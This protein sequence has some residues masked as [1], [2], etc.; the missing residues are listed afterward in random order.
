V[1]S[2]P[3]LPHVRWQHASVNTASVKQRTNM[4]TADSERPNLV[5]LQSD[6]INHFKVKELNFFVG[7]YIIQQSY[8][9][10]DIHKQQLLIT[11]AL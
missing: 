11:F 5:Y 2:F 9:D 1:Y 4:A 10:V 3:L 6:S 7:D 8:S